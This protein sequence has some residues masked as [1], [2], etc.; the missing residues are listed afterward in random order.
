MR[1]ITG[2][3]KGRQIKIPKEINYIRPTSDR[4]KEGMFGV[5]A[6]R[7]DF[8]G[9]EVLDLFAGTGNLGFECISRG[10]AHAFFIDGS[11]EALRII[12]DNAT[13]LGIDAQVRSQCS[14]IMRFIKGH[15]RAYDLVFADPPYDFPEMEDL[16]DHV[17]NDGWL[18][19]D[20]W[21]ILEHDARHNF[22]ERPN[23]VFMKPYGRTIVT[24]FVSY[25]VQTV[26]PEETDE[27]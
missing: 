20:G 5:I 14:D 16:I 18:K 6:A 15:P 26:S 1:I 8:R 7:K 22:S 2:K 19:D 13:T 17:L 3:L 21:F 27:P 25:P 11:K 12:N 4:T 23:C 10:S 24:I 9:T